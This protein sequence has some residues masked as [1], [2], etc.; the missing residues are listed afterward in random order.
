[1]VRFACCALTLLL[2]LAPACN[3]APAVDPAEQAAQLKKDLANAA[4]RV[5]DEKWK[6]AEGML[7]RVLAAEPNNPE[8][9]HLLA[10]VRLHGDKNA[11]EALSLVDKAIAANGKS[12]EYHATRAQA[13]EKSGKDAD[14]AAAW[15]KAFELQPDNGQFGLHQGQA[16]KRAK[17]FDQAEAVFREVIKVDEA[18]QYVYSELG[19]VLR[20]QGKIDEALN[21]YAKAMIKYQGDKMAHA[22]AAQI[23]ETKGDTLKAVDEWSTYIRMDCCSEYSNSVAKKRIAALQQG[24][25]D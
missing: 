19:D 17:Q 23:Y 16:Y 22:G 9:L 10:Q 11:A 1:M 21:T 18:A 25:A 13:L 5:G 4:A 12:P 7:D 3:N 2:A 6:E 8:A 14:A 15:G 20:E 24:R